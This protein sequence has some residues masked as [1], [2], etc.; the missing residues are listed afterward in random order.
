MHSALLSAL[1]VLASPVEAWAL[2]ASHILRMRHADVRQLRWWLMD[3][4]HLHCSL[5]R[6]VWDNAHFC[7]WSQNSVQV[8][9]MLPQCAC[10]C[11]E[12]SWHCPLEVSALAGTRIRTVIGIAEGPCDILTWHADGAAEEAGGRQDGARPQPEQRRR[13]CPARRDLRAQV[14]SRL[15]GRVNMDTGS[16]AFLD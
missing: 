16:C 15:H 10:P 4:L 2:E 6:P 11:F 1:A 14:R 3:F 12:V 8:Q 7:R 9:P 5:A 13:A